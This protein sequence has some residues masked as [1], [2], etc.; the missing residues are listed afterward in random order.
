MPHVHKHQTPEMDECIHAC[1]E[2]HDALQ[3]AVHDC[4]KRGGPHAS[5]KHIGV[6]LD[7]AQMAHTAHDFMLRHSELHEVTCRACAEICDACAK[8]CDHAGDEEL[9]QLCRRCAASCRKPHGTPA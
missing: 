5:A 9:A 3:H 1:E 7:C 8:M 4:L 6:L 2:V